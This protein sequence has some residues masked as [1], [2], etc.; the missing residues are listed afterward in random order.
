[1]FMTTTVNGKDGEPFVL[2]LQRAL[3]GAKQS[4][5]LWQLTL[6]KFLVEELHFVNSVCD[7]CLYA[8]HTKR[9]IILLGVYVDDIVCA[10]SNA[11]R[12]E[13]RGFLLVI[14][15]RTDALDT[16]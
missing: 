5:R 15:V 10:V 3:Y 2:K 9:G 12:K 16:T 13:V 8:L 1:M 4:S 11:T 14:R 6:R 7:P